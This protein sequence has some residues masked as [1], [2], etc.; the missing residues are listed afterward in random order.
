M[1]L[2][3]IKCPRCGGE[4]IDFEDIH[5]SVSGKGTQISLGLK[6]G[7]CTAIQDQRL[8][9][10]FRFLSRIRHIEAGPNSFGIEFGEKTFGIESNEDSLLKTNQ[11]RNA[12]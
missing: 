2:A 10:I 4:D 12:S 8:N 6:C 7:G 1:L 9:K 5:T 3:D 11:K